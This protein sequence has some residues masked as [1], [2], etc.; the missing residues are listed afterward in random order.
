MNRQNESTSSRRAGDEGGTNS[1]N[2]SNNNNNN[3]HG[4]DRQQHSHTHQFYFVDHR[5][6]GDGVDDEEAP[7][8]VYFINY[9]FTIPSA[10]LR[11]DT[12][13]D[14]A[15]TASSE[16]SSSSRQNAGTSGPWGFQFRRQESSGVT[17]NTDGTS[18]DQNGSTG[19][20]G[21]GGGGPRYWQQFN[22]GQGAT[23]FYTPAV[24]IRFPFFT[25]GPFMTDDEVQKPRASERA[26]ARLKHLNL[27][28]IA[29]S[30]RVCPIC[31]EAYNQMADNHHH[32]HKGKAT[33]SDDPPIS[34]PDEMEADPPESVP[35]EEPPSHGAVEM[36]CKH[37]FGFSCIKEWLGSSNTCPLCRTTVESQDDYLRSTGRPPENDP[38]INSG[39]RLFD[40]I[41]NIIPNMMSQAQANGDSAAGSAENSTTSMADEDLTDNIIIENYRPPTA[42]DPSINTTNDPT[43]SNLHD[44]RPVHPTTMDTSSQGTTPPTPSSRT[45]PINQFPSIRRAGLRPLASIL[46][47][48]RNRGNHWQSSYPNSDNNS[49]ANLTT[50]GPSETRYSQ[51]HHPYRSAGST[52]VSRNFDERDLRC[53]SLPLSLCLGPG[54]G[55]DDDEEDNEDRHRIIRLD[56]GHGYHVPCLRVCMRAHGDVDIPDLTGGSDGDGGTRQVWCMRCRRYQNVSNNE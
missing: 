52:P 29:E 15:S 37:R 11:D 34:V 2:N 3:N 16:H 28:D 54:S 5:N 12:S 20:G 41:F 35:D 27:D 18:N 44:P 8:S 26:I 51:R 46:R 24:D 36:P 38:N 23:F 10:T 55:I 30:E 33:A 25:G 42:N 22:N 43:N 19:G 4:T 40:L 47:S 48:F 56:C 14:D 39:R 7:S 13:S 9:S 32:H 1:N 49:E 31:F 50:P 21:G 17:N 53:A 6:P 45:T